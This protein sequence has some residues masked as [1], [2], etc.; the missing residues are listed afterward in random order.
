[1]SDDGHKTFYG[2]Q[3]EMPWKTKLPELRELAYQIHQS[4]LGTE[5]TR[6]DCQQ[7][8]NMAR[9]RLGLE[10]VKQEIRKT[11]VVLPSGLMVRSDSHEEEGFD[12]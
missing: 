3:P 12:T 9:V 11:W 8:W 6:D 1:M 2:Q 10:P 7:C 4:R 5:A